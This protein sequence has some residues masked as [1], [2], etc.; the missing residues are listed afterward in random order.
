MLISTLKHFHL[1]SVQS[2]EM[3]CGFFNKVVCNFKSA[4]KHLLN[5]LLTV[6]PLLMNLCPIVRFFWWWANVY[7]NIATISSSV[8]L[9]VPVNPP[10]SLT[11]SQSIL[12]VRL[13]MRNSLIQATSPSR[14]S[15][16]NLSDLNCDLH[17]LIIV[18]WRRLFV[19]SSTN[20]IWCH[21]AYVDD[22]PA[23]QESGLGVA[24]WFFW[25]NQETVDKAHLEDSGEAVGYARGRRY[26]PA[27]P[28]RRA[29]SDWFRAI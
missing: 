3:A 5:C 10:M 18:N 1:L 16:S 4:S 29:Y 22:P 26:S 11:N 23:R 20:A 13:S 21:I 27:T 24:T 12:N 19:C 15:R 9:P 8:M 2:S 14:I 17:L 7:R 28:L 6:S 25:R